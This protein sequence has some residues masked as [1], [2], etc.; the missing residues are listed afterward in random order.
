[1]FFPMKS[2][3]SILLLFSILFLIS[4]QSY[5]QSYQLNGKTL[6]TKDQVQI[7]IGGAIKLVKPYNNASHFSAVFNEIALRTSPEDNLPKGLSANNQ[8]KELRVRKFLERN[9][10]SG[11]RVYV[12]AG[13]GILNEAIDIDY[14]LENGEVLVARPNSDNQNSRTPSTNKPGL[15]AKP[16][17]FPWSKKPNLSPKVDSTSWHSIPP[18]RDSL[19]ILK[20][21]QPNKLPTDSITKTKPSP[22]Q[23]VKSDQENLTKD[24]TKLK[25]NPITTPNINAPS[26][27]NSNIQIKPI[28]VSP[29]Q[30]ENIPVKR[31]DEMVQDHP[32]PSL[33]EDS[34]KINNMGI[35]DSK[36]IN[37]VEE[38]NTPSP[39]IPGA[40]ASH[41]VSSLLTLKRPINPKP[42]KTE[43]AT[44]DSKGYSKYDKLKQLKE[45]LD[46]GILTK[47]EF[48]S[49]KKK[50]LS[51]N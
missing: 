10:K 17:H 21:N 16:I 25:I 27:Y 19:V 48:E 22:I 34:P 39:V 23:E 36:S 32:K 14:A 49:E 47:D 5:S 45:L 11:K 2:I 33:I 41:S 30:E 6:I 15:F 24:E 37:S 7:E 9:E 20:S 35:K 12:I 4:F 51:E 26:V 3:K 44:K 38:T 1:M 40:D 50:I 18:K 13:N 29:S 31:T 28:A 8:G 46:Q 43:A 42:E